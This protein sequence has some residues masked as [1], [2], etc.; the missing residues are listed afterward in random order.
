MSLLQPKQKNPPTKEER[1]GLVCDRLRNMVLDCYKELVSIQN[2]GIDEIWNN[3]Q[4]TPQEIMDAL[5]ADGIKMFQFHGV[6]T[7]IIAQ[8]AANE[9]VA[10][11]LKL[12]KKAFTVE[13]GKI[14]ILED[15]Y[16][17]S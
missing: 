6:L 4:F 7:D 9:G 10:P 16:V 1:L 12:P 3:P 14:K 5:G 2:R 13:A 17:V 11:S 15:P 8:L